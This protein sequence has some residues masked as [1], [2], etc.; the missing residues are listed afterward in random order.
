MSV[1]QVEE[2]SGVT[3]AELVA[4]AALVDQFAGRREALTAAVAVLLRGVWRS[5]VLV[6]TGRVSSA[7]AARVVAAAQVM[8]PVEFAREAERMT[9]V[10]SD[11]LYDGDAL[12]VLTRDLAVGSERGQ[13]QVAA[14]AG[15]FER[16]VLKQ[17]GVSAPAAATRT[18]VV[19]VFEAPSVSAPPASGVGSFRRGVDPLDVYDRVARTFRWERSRESS[20]EEALAAAEA[21]LA[22]LIEDDLM[23]AQRDTFDEIVSGPDPG[24]VSGYRRVLRPELSKFGSCGLCIV[25]ADRVYTR[26]DLMPLHARCGCIVLPIV[27]GKDPG[28]SLNSDDLDRLYEAAGTTSGRSKNGA[29]GLKQVRVQTVEHGELGPV[30]VRQGQ[31]FTTQAEAE[32]RQG[33]AQ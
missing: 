19:P 3:A 23:V 7:A 20:M 31:K 12:Q 10:G 29:R 25:A 22:R 24:E 21:R 1:E 28:L 5:F 33:S 32:A 18:P 8:S 2:R 27:A 16:Q 6:G 13:G 14:L 17:L 15:E 26:D 30:L 4:V 11:V 9:R